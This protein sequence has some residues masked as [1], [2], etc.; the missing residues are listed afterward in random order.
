MG[1]AAFVDTHIRGELQL[2]IMGS[3][4]KDCPEL[5]YTLIQS[6]STE[7]KPLVPAEKV[8]KSK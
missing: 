2:A 5:C 1:F 3:A 7:K 6:I 8:W 4:K